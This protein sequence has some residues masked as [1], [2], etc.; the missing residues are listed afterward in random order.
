MAVGICFVASVSEARPLGSATR[1]GPHLRSGFRSGSGACLTLTPTSIT[2]VRRS[3]IKEFLRQIMIES[4]ENYIFCLR[5]LLILLR[6]VDQSHIVM[7][8]RI[9]AFESDGR[10]QRFDGSG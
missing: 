4:L 1:S 10:A 8:G 3:S 2:H 6:D 7:S 5:A 9:I